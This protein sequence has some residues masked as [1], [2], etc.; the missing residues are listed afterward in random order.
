MKRTTVRFVVFAS[1]VAALL[2]AGG[3]SKLLR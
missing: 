2:L 1:S 3:A